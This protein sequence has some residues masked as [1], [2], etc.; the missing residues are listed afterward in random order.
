MLR[1]RCKPLEVRVNVA[2]EGILLMSATICEYVSQLCEA[3][4]AHFGA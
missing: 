1:S 3:E 2:E 4:E